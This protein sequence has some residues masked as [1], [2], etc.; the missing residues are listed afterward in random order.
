MPPMPEGVEEG[1]LKGLY[2]VQSRPGQKKVKAHIL[3]SG[4]IIKFCAQGAGNSGGKVRGVGGCVERHQ[5]QA[6][7]HRC[8]S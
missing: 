3:G 8:D 4:P 7:A 5:L 1:I 2:Q 6:V